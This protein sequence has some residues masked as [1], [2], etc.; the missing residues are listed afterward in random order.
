MQIAILEA[1]RS[2]AIVEEPVPE[3]GPDEV[4]IRVAACGV[5]SSDLH[6]WADGWRSG[7][8]RRLGHEVSGVIARVGPAVRSVKPGDH[9]AAWVT[10]RG[11]AESVAVKAEYCVPA[12]EVPLDL[13]LAEP[14][15]RVAQALRE[16]TE[17]LE[18]QARRTAEQAHV[19]NQLLD[20][21]RHILRLQETLGRNLQL[22]ANAGTFQQTLQ[23]LVA[24]VHLLTARTDPAPV[25]LT[26]PGGPATRTRQGHAA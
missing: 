8:P 12:G 14:L 21:E 2:F 10:G 11:Y 1:P 7:F 4:L 22:L 13:A 15:A 20:D 5:C 9:V 17:A 23:T 3:I 6:V 16:T 19:L 24:A 25:P 18:G 26:P